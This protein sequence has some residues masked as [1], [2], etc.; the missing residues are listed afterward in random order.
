[1]TRA[2]SN[3]RCCRPDRTSGSGRPA[4]SRTRGRGWP[5]AT[6][7]RR[8]PT[9][10]RRTPTPTT[11]SPNRPGR[12][13]SRPSSRRSSR[14]SRRP[15]SPCRCC[16]AAGGTSRAPSRESRTPC[17]AAA[18][19]PDVPDTPVPSSSTATSRPRV[20][21]TSTCTTSNHRRTTPCWPGRATST[22]ASATPC[23][24]ATSHTGSDLDE[25]TGT[26]SWGGVAWSA[27]HDWLF[28][29]RPD[30]QMRPHEIWRHRLGT[31]PADDV[32]V[33]REDDER[34]FLHVSDTRSGRWI[35]IASASKTSG[36][37]FVLRA[38]DPRGHAGLVRPRTPDV[39]YGIDDWGDRFVVL[40]NLDAPDFR[41]MT[42]PHDDPGR[43]SD[44]V[45]HEAGRRLT[46]AEPFADHLVVHE[47]KDAQPRVRVLRRDGTSEVLDFGAEPHDLSIGA[48][49]E[50][51]DDVAAALLP[52]A[53]DS[54]IRVRPRPRHRRAGAAQADTDARRRPRR[55]RR[56]AHLG[57]RRRR[58]RR[59][60]RH[61]PPPRHG[62]RRHGAVRRLRLRRLRVL[63]GAM[64]QRRPPVAARPRRRLRPRPP[65]WRR[66]ARAV[67]VP[68]RQAAQQAGHVHRHDRGERSPRGGRLRRRRSA[69]AARRQRRRPARR[70]V[71]HDATG[72]LSRRRRRGPLR[73]RR[74]DDER[75]VAA[76]DRDG[77]GG[78]GRSA[79]PS[80]SPATSPAT[81]RTTTRCPPTIRRSSSPP[82]STTR[83]SPTTSRRSGSPGCV[84]SAPG[85]HRP[86]VLRTEMGA[87]HGGRSG[88]YDAWRDEARVV[89]FL[90]AEL[91]RCRPADRI[92]GGV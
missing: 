77:V 66:R 39:E 29:A 15:T 57:D 52:V 60:D 56:R 91:A 81:R 22:A 44:L 85:S 24:S 68:R 83:G 30:D 8:S 11:T 33:H 43:W 59:A 84:R 45:A 3:P 35:V 46:E 14:G 6:T 37:S 88:R 75:P 42:A 20:T 80:R 70:R 89:A 53:D 72:A 4:S 67:V 55:L 63:A 28:Y 1:M 18:A 48:N 87:G 31:S 9:S 27:G 54:P 41:L 74:D 32:L 79:E 38:D 51:D 76:A 82:G 47:W 50:W 5:T 78:V 90:V 86:L 61:R 73:R 25:I 92:S 34:F 7:R 13:S 17:S 21:S 49:P 58:R 64:V 40:T 36:E 10:K 71:H 19:T 62:P 2:R 12:H 69:G 16:T 26:S 65:A 23:A